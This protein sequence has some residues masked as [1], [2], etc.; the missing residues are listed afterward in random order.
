MVGADG[1]GEFSEAS[2]VES[3]GADFG[4]EKFGES[5]STVAHPPDV[6]KMCTDWYTGGMRFHSVIQIAAPV[7]RVW[8]LTVD[9][10]GWPATTP[11][12]TSVKRVE[13]GPIGVGSSA[14]VKQPGQRAKLWTVT[15]FEPLTMFAWS[16]RSWGLVVTGTHRIEATATGVKNTLTVD[17]DGPLSRVVGLAAGR[18]IRKAIR[19]ENEGFKRAAEA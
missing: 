8:E 11:T 15:T 9:V 2:I 4:G 1:R 6:T 14:W 10:E 13:R 17:V 7:S 12:L 3:V 19:T 18:S 5:L 16:T